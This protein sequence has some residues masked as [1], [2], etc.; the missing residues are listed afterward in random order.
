MCEEERFPPVHMR[1]LEELI[2][3]AGPVMPWLKPRLFAS[4]LIIWKD[5]NVRVSKKVE[6]NVRSWKENQRS[7]KKSE[8]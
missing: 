3:V 8:K 4:S 7:R 2:T 1:Q 5:A 6:T